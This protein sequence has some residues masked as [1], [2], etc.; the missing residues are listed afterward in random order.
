MLDARRA[1]ELQ[2]TRVGAASGAH[3]VA[4][5]VPRTSHASLLVD[6]HVAQRPAHVW[7]NGGMDHDLPADVDQAIEAA[8]DLD[9]EREAAAQ[10][11]LVAERDRRAGAR[12]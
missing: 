7:A 4:V 3:V 8:G 2:R 1:G 12:R 11:C 5:A 9:L 6:G 10:E